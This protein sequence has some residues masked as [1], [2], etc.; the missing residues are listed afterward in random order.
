MVFGG[1][2]GRPVMGIDQGIQWKSME[3]IYKYNVI[4]DIYGPASGMYVYIYVCKSKSFF[5]RFSRQ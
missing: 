5:L 1:K 4:E 2:S 3:Y